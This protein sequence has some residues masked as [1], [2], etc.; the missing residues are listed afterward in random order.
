MTQ[1][2]V[3][4]TP[5]PEASRDIPYVVDVQSDTLDR[6]KRRVIVPLARRA[7]LTDIEPALNPIF[8]IE[9]TPC[10]LMPLDIAAVLESD[11][12]GVVGSLEAESD[13]IVGA[14][15]LLFARY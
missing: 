11:L 14:L 3:R 7:A 9:G 2:D 13:R 6:S 8:E 5:V 10:V 4:R 12:G 1:Y 15:D